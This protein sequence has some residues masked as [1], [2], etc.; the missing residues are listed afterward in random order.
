MGIV[1]SEKKRHAKKPKLMKIY[2]TNGLPEIV[3]GFPSATMR[4]LLM[5]YRENTEKTLRMMRI[6]RR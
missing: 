4:M 5:I 6:C 3:Y 2:L 1:K